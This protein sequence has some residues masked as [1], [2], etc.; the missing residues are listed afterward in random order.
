[1]ESSALP[2]ETRMQF[3]EL[4]RSQAAEA[5]EMRK[6]VHSWS[7]MQVAELEQQAAEVVEMRKRVQSAEAVRDAATEEAMRATS[8]L[9]NLEARLSEV[10]TYVYDSKGLGKGPFGH[11]QELA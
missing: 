2:A 4:E 9:N 1:M 8:M 7:I 11:E 5:S 3:A 10:C 6:R